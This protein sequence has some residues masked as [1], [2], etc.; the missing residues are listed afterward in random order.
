MKKIQ[1][2]TSTLSVRE[3]IESLS[4]GRFKYNGD[5]S[6][7][8]VLEKDCDSSASHASLR[9]LSGGV[10]VPDRHLI[11]SGCLTGAFVGTGRT[12]KAAS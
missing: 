10:E 4:A 11:P 6:L 3:S 5:S 1:L 2:H 9:D 12:R 7:D 8:E